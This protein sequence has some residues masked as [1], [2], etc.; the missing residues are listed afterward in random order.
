MANVNLVRLYQTAANVSEH[1]VTALMHEL[2]TQEKYE[3]PEADAVAAKKATITEIKE[4]DE[5]QGEEREEEQRGQVGS[6]ADVKPGG[7][8]T[9][10]GCG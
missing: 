6:P 1:N 8:V 9:R 3:M 7:D 2:M 5:E 10:V 4:E